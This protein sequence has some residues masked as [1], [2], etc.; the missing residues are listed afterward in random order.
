MYGNT[1]C[2]SEPNIK[3]GPG[4]LRDFH[5]VLWVSMAKF[6]INKLEG[7]ER[8]GIIDEHEKMMS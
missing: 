3:E 1:I 4:A 2:I 8:R 7:L 5:T 6:E